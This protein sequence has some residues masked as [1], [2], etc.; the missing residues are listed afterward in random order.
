M[1]LLTF[2]FINFVVAFISDIILNDLSS[3]YGIIKSL[4]PYFYKQSIVI[5]GLAAS[6]TIEFALLITI[7]IYYLIRKTT[8]PR[9]NKEL[10][11][12]LSLAFIIGYITDIVIYK[13]KIFGNR[14][15]KYYE[16]Y[17]SGLWGALSLIF[18]IILS[19]II[20]KKILPKLK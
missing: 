20:Q 18:S 11:Y 12:F 16:E 2:L 10:L 19:Y 9:N 15:D 5:S 1:E 14:L 7:V 8:I 13:K 6:L 4:K 3:N 17:G